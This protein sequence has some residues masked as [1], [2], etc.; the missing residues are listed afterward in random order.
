MVQVMRRIGKR[1]VML[2]MACLCLVC[3]PLESLAATKPINS[4]SVKVSSK[5]KAGDTQPGI[6]IGGSAADGE[7]QVSSSGSY[8]TVTDAEWV[9]KISGTMTTATAPRLKIVLTPVDVSDH[10]FL[11]SYKAS[12]VKV[13]G[14][15]FVSARRDGDD[16]VVTVRLNPVKGKYDEPADAYWNENNL[17][18]ARWEPGENDSKNY[19][20]QLYR[21]G[22]SV[23]KIDRTTA[24]N[25]N[26]YPYMT[27]AG[28]YKFRVRAITGT[29]NNAKYGSNSSWTESGELQIT[30]R[31]VSDGKGRQSSKSTVKQ[32]TQ[33]SVGWFKDGTNWKYRYPSGSLCNKGWRSEER[34]VGKECM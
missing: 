13:S 32:G 2:I 20:V 9:D 27:T 5:L 34:R 1:A 19:E 31:D 6:S 18:E 15:T 10:Y 22:K 24:K 28:E 12:S 21:N 25:Y 29:D 23:F 3:M 30:D 17:G 11:A 4:V 8:Y 14:G 7:V 16:L 33:E 26:F